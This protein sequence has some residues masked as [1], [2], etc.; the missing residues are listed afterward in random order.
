MKNS[1]TA[2]MPY[3]CCL[4][5]LPHSGACGAGLLSRWVSFSNVTG[6]TVPRKLTAQLQK[7]ICCSLVYK[8]QRG[9]EETR[10]P[11][12]GVKECFFEALKSLSGSLQTRVNDNEG[13]GQGRHRLTATTRH[14]L[15]CLTTKHQNWELLL[16]QIS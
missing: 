6:H 11:T 5:A 13:T 14:S 16:K 12:F 1:C 2:K 15:G 8:P 3:H 7:S 4:C 10:A 9:R